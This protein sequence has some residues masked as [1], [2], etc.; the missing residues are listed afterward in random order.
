M[1]KIEHCPVCEGEDCVIQSG[2]GVF[3]CQN[4][5]EEYFTLDKVK[6]FEEE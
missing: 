4:C 1:P 5:G 2:K 3:E 6:V